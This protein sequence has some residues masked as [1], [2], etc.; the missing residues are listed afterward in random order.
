MKTTIISFKNFMA[1]ED[2]KNV[3]TRAM[4][5]AADLGV[6]QMFTGKVSIPLG[7]VLGKTVASLN[8]QGLVKNNVLEGF[9]M[10]AE[11]AE[12]IHS[13]LLNSLVDKLLHTLSAYGSIDKNTQKTKKGWIT[14]WTLELDED[15]FMMLKKET[16]VYTPVTLNKI[17]K[18]KLQTKLSN[19]LGISTVV[20]GVDKEYLTALSKQYVDFNLNEEEFNKC[21]QHEYSHAEEL[22]DGSI[23]YTKTLNTDKMVTAHRTNLAA[24]NGKSFQVMEELESRGRTSKQINAKKGMNLYGKTWETQSFKLGDKTVAYDARQSGY[25]ILA[26]LLGVKPMARISGVYGKTGLGDLYSDLFGKVLERVFNGTVSRA[27]AKRP[28][29]MLAYMAGM[30]A[31]LTHK[32]KGEQSIWD[33]LAPE[34]ANLKE[35]CEK[36]EIELYAQPELRP[37]MILRETVRDGHYKN[38]VMPTWRLPESSLYH[39]TRSETSYIGFGGERTTPEFTFIGDDNKTHIL[40]VHIEMFRAK[41]K[42]SAILAAIVHSIDGWIKK[43]VTLDV[44]NAGGKCL[45]KHDEFIVDE[46]HE[47]LMIKSYHT[48]M[49][50]VATHRK[51]FLQEPLKQ[52]GYLINLDTLVDEN[53][54]A[55]GAFVPAMVRNASNGLKHEWTV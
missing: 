30:T 27:V 42:Y 33:L 3:S 36:L 44:I 52:C 54:E 51:Q 20:E 46:E 15:I 43:K 53:S 4:A 34:G 35:Y 22:M 29:Q 31:I 21:I 23:K 5:S 6:K 32:E 18:G 47:E 11:Y 25:Q 41:A 39:F 37:I 28:A 9:D 16:K 40:S 1:I 2:H 48:W 26:G 7:S 13:K 10:D 49:A 19:N 12:T 14:H 17:R 8:R 38:Y 45:V 24:L 55:F 50:Y